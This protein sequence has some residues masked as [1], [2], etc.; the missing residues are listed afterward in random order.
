MLADNKIADMGRYD[1]A[2]L[3]DLLK[4][5]STD[6]LGLTGTGY[7]LE[8]D[9]GLLERKVEAQLRFGVDQAGAIDEFDKMAGFNTSHPGVEYFDVI[10][11]Y[12]Q[13][14]DARNEF[15]ETI[16]RAYQPGMKTMRCPESWMKTSVALDTD[17]L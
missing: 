13:D 7:D 5:L 8:H 10:R 16:G 6:T 14:L 11:V 17:V 12:F 4:K 3:V 9:L 2:L 15:F 1:D